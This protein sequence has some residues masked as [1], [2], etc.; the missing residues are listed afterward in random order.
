MLLNASPSAK[1]SII[2]EM[3]KRDGNVLNLTWLCEIAGVTR[4]GYYFWLKAEKAREAGEAQDIADL[5]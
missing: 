3:T 5:R 1:F 4:A 2:R